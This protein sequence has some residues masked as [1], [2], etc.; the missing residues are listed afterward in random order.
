MAEEEDLLDRLDAMT[1]VFDKSVTKGKKGEESDD[2]LNLLAEIKDT[3][4]DMGKKSKSSTFY[5]DARTEEYLQEIMDNTPDIKSRSQALSYVVTW[6]KNLETK[7]KEFESKFRSMDQKLELMSYRT[8]KLGAQSNKLAML[9]NSLSQISLDAGKMVKEVQGLVKVLSKVKKLNKEDVILLEI[10][11]LKEQLANVQFA[12]PGSGGAV[13]KLNISL[14]K[15][16][17]KQRASEMNVDASSDLLS[18]F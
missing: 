9:Q 10:K 11:E 6:H 5:L 8:E 1:K 18:M 16:G 3:K 2:A 12:A 7:L 4:E 14:K 13:P 17:Q 15:G